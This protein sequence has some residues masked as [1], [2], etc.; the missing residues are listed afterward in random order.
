VLGI[1]WLEKNELQLITDF[2]QEAHY[3]PIW[4]TDGKR[5]IF[6]R[7]IFSSEGQEKSGLYLFDTQTQLLTPFHKNT[8]FVVNS[9][10]R[11]PRSDTLVYWLGYEIYVME[12]GSSPISIGRGSFPTWHPNGKTICYLDEQGLYQIRELDLQV[13]DQIIGGGFTATTI[14]LGLE[15]LFNKDN[16]K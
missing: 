13:A 16:A 5:I 2:N 7:I 12:L 14:P 9:M 1:W 11:S 10:T 8:Q 4:L 15:I 6:T 3:Y